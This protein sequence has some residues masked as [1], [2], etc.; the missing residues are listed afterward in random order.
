MTSMYRA[1]TVSWSL[2]IT[3]GSSQPHLALYVRDAVGLRVTDPASPP[4]LLHRPPDRRALLTDEERTRAAEQ[5]PS[6]W[7]AILRLDTRFHDTSERRGTS[8]QAAFLTWVRAHA[9]ER[10]RTVG[11][12][13]EFTALHGSP[14]LQRA[15]VALWPEGRSWAE[16]RS[17]PTAEP[18]SPAV[19][20]REVAEAVIAEHG[21][22]PDA[23]RG[24]VLVL[25]V[26]GVWS[27]LLQPGV[28]LCSA[29]C[30]DAPEAWRRVV[31][32]VFESGLEA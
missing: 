32:Q 25:A 23:V 7:H 19:V 11:E 20:T 10:A 31:R 22:S 6:W 9:A 2:S 18:G 14:E 12:P 8:D 26:D 13:P 17:A 5:W 4:P 3:E 27:H 1:G 24:T 30:Q 21:I 29:V 15:A 28:M 16:R